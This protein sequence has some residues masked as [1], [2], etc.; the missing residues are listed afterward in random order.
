MSI[1]NIMEGFKN[2]LEKSEVDLGAATVD[3]VPPRSQDHAMVQTPSNDNSPTVSKTMSGRDDNDDFVV[4]PGD[5]R[6]LMI[7]SLTGVDPTLK[8]RRKDGKS[9]ENFSGTPKYTSPEQ[10]S[11]AFNA[12]WHYDQ[13]NF[14]DLIHDVAKLYPDKQKVCS[15]LIQLWQTFRQFLHNQNEWWWDKPKEKPQVKKRPHVV[16]FQ[17]NIM[18]FKECYKGFKA[19]QQLVKEFTQPE[20]YVDLIRAWKNF[21]AEW[22]RAA[23]PIIEQLV[24]DDKEGR[25]AQAQEYRSSLKK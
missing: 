16:N 19:A 15:N 21:Y 7:R 4:G 10:A 17:V 13:D 5:L 24:A 2:W 20:Q 22:L 11:R 8:N 18:R 23:Q 14:E 6:A 1:D 12:H 9:I 3:Y 25:E